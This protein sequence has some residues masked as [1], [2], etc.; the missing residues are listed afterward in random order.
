MIQTISITVRGKVQGVFFRQSSRDKAL[1]LGITGWVKN[2]SDGSVSIL[3][4]GNQQQLD[5]F[6][7]W[8]RQGPPKA[9]VAGIDVQPHTAESFKGFVILRF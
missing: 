5:E 7:A 2:L 1:Q 3:A 6:L 8:C 4:S 9:A